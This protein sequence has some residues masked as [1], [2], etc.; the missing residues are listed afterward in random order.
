MAMA[1]RHGMQLLVLMVVTLPRCSPS[2]PSSL[3]VAYA[4]IV[5]IALSASATTTT[6]TTWPT[7]IWCGL[8]PFRTAPD[9]HSGKVTV[10]RAAGVP[11]RC[12]LINVVRTAKLVPY[13]VG[14]LPRL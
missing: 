8:L 9:V 10:S 5:L 6:T 7:C 12:E 14:E 11:G 2:S 13:E 4:S 3:T 1:Q